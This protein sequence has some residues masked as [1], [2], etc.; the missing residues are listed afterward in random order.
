[1]VWSRISGSLILSLYGLLSLS[2]CSSE[3]STTLE[4]EP[5]IERPATADLPCNDAWG[6]VPATWTQLSHDDGQSNADLTSQSWSI[7]DIALSSANLVEATRFDIDRPARIVGVSVQYGPLPEAGRWPLT[8]GLHQ[9][10]DTTALIFGRWMHSGRAV[11][12][13]WI[14]KPVNG[15]TTFYPSRH[16]DAA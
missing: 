15:W 13:E 16:P 11:A 6:V 1:M 2:A 12:A 5:P 9:D 14:S 8:L 10:L 7:G 3:Q 4:S